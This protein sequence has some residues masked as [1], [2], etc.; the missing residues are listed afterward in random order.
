MNIT[1]THAEHISS[2]GASTPQ[3]LP[4][5]YLPGPTVRYVHLPPRLQIDKTIQRHVDFLDINS[6]RFQRGRLK[7][8]P[9]GQE[10][11]GAKTTIEVRLPMPAARETRPEY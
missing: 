9:V 2:S 4:F 3:P 7:P 11:P 6:K 8:A 5:L 10:P 1:L